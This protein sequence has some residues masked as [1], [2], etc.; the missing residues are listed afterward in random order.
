MANSNPILNFPHLRKINGKSMFYVDGKPFLILGLQWDCDS[1]FSPEDMN[2][3]FTEA[4]K[5]GC[6]SVALPLCWN[7]IEQTE[8]TYDFTILDE[9]LKQARANDLKI[10]LLWFGTY[11]NACLNYAPD[12][13]KNDTARFRRAM[14]S[15]GKELKNFACPTCSLTH[16]K[17]Q[18]AIEAVFHHL[19]SMDSEKHIV[20]IFQMENEAGLLGTDRCYCQ[21]CNSQF[22][23]GKYQ[24]KYG[25]RAN[26]A[27][28]AHSIAKFSDTLAGVAKGIYSLPIYMNCALAEENNVQRPGEYF[29]GGPVDRVLDVY[30]E[31]VKH[32]DFI[33]P[34]IYQPGY[35]DFHAISQNYMWAGNP[36]YIAEHAS[37]KGSRAE[38]NVFYALGSFNAIG[39]DA[40]AIDCAFPN[41]YGKL[42]ADPVDGRWSKEAFDLRDSYMAIRNAMVPVAIA[43][44]NGKLATFV[45]EDGDYG[46][47][48]N[49]DGVIAE[50]SYK[51]PDKL[52]RGMIAQVSEDELIVLGKGFTIRFYDDGEI[53]LLIEF[54]TVGVFCGEE[55]IPRH[56]MRREGEDRTA[57][58]GVICSSVIRVKLDPK[59]SS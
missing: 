31:T 32:I 48:L 17:D 30:R 13:I 33:S 25:S 2:P 8:G 28:S 24:E 55:F 39:F 38:K 59:Q 49:L 10:V 56:P 41:T 5:M 14:T 4:A 45:Q 6:N 46:I 7:V 16:E 53:P 43:Q 22:A 27:F 58:F 12:Y 52:S 42:L 50:I 34:D 23:S 20:I 18:A 57:P 1:C 15:D 44:N 26:E 21:E 29:S 3:L 51:D 19:K 9:M 36:L 11:K 35:R 54:A 37:G 47:K 40:W